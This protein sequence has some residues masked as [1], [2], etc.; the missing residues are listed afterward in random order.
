MSEV[1]RARYQ[2]LKS[3]ITAHDFRYYVLDDPTLEDRQYD[4]LYHELRELE[5]KHPAWIDPSSP[6]QRV[7]GA[8]RSEFQTVEHVSRMYSLDNSYDENDVQEFLR[9]NRDAT[10]NS[11]DLHYCVEPKLD[12]ASVEILYRDGK[13]VG[14][15]TRGDGFQG[16]DI[17]ENLRTIG[18]L[19]LAIE[20]QG[21]LTLRGEV[22]IFRRDLEQINLEREANGEAPFANPRNAASGSLRLLDP[23]EVK[24]RRLRAFIYQVLEGAEF[25]DGHEEALNQ[26]GKWGLPVHGLQRSF[27]DFAGVWQRIQEIDGM[28]AQFPYDTDGAVIKVNR[29]EQQKRLGE[30][31][32]YPRWAIAY[33]FSAEQAATRVLGITIQVGRTGALTPVAELEP[34]QLAGTVVSRASLHNADIIQGLKLHVGATVLIEKAGE[35]I[36]QIISLVE[37]S[38]EDAEVFQMPS[39]C[40]SCS[41]KVVKRDGESVIRCVNR[42]CPA[43]IKTSIHYFARRFAMDIDQLGP[44][45]VEQLVESKKIER[46]SDLYRLSVDD[47]MSLDRVGQ[48]GASKVVQAILSSKEQ[49]FERLLTGL[50]I[51]LIGQ[52]AGKQIAQEF[53]S[54]E[55]LLAEPSESIRQRL[56]AIHGIGDKMIDSFINYLEDPRERALLLDLQEL[57]VSR[58]SEK[59]VLPSDGTLLGMS[60]CATGKLSKKRELIY[61][62]VKRAG[63]EAHS[64]VKK[65]TTY[66]IT[67]EDVG[68]AKIEAAKKKDVKI[69]SESDFEKL[70]SGEKLS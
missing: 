15:A 49:P 65:G 51:D 41:E 56:S 4:A 64:S 17:S 50:G 26:L 19:P 13:L 7:G 6:T 70:L 25:S 23:R 24:K 35:I 38:A 16:E 60:F 58:S 9:R 14:G 40:P 10:P 33:K 20:Y 57:S 11:E 69:I 53:G 63:G 44:A 43:I 1:E 55:V 36:P 46:V 21:P 30:N 34:V 59:E 45:L 48:K 3:E 68:A 2:E 8:P 47:L 5:A 39:H 12:G 28:R 66:L 37:S 62:E 32:K 29:F 67:G 42:V 22:V 52:S 27:S 31:S 18:T 61:E 54:L